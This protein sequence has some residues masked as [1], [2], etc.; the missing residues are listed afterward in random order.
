MTLYIQLKHYREKHYSHLSSYWQIDKRTI[1]HRYTS[2]F[3]RVVLNRSALTRIS[4]IFFV[5]EKY[6]SLSKLSP[7]HT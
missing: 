5:A 7:R 3:V 4:W 2:I 6:T 1:G